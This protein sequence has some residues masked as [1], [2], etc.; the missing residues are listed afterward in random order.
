MQCYALRG[1]GNEEYLIPKSYPLEIMDKRR[2]RDIRRELQE[3]R[4]MAVLLTQRA[5]R[6]EYHLEQHEAT[7]IEV[8]F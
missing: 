3:L 7:Q 8:N 4:Q 5:E 6:I 1:N 2:I